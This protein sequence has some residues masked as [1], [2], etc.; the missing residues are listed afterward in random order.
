[1]KYGII[2]FSA[3]V[4]ALAILLSACAKTVSTPVAEDYCQ[5]DAE[6]ACGVHA[7]T[8]DCFYGN[9]NYVD[10]RQQCPDFCNGIAGNFEIKCVENKCTQVSTRQL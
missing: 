4:I 7:I 8:G 1:M 10:S 6:C 9:Q 3:V 2:I 5:S